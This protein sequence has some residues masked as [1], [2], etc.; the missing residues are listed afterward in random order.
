MLSGAVGLIAGTALLIAFILA[1]RLVTRWRRRRDLPLRSGY[2]LALAEYL[3][4]VTPDPPQ[5]VGPNERRALRHVALASLIELRGRERERVTELLERTGIVEE[6]TG[7]LRSRRRL[8]RRR[9]ADALAEIRSPE[10]APALRAGLDD[11]DRAVR[12]S[13]GRAL[14][15][16]GDAEALGELVAVA[17]TEIDHSPGAVADLLLALAA[18]NPRLLAEALPATASRPLRRLLIAIIGAERLVEYA[19]LLRSALAERDDELVARAAGG[20]GLMGDAESVEEL[21]GLLDDRDGALSVR[22]AAAEALGRIGDPAAVGALE[23]ALG[24]GDWTL[25]Q[26]A[27]EALSILGVPGEDMLRRVAASGSPQA[28]AH[29]EVALER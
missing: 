2:E 8:Q 29:A 7:E 5:P 18:Q 24:S 11:R 6:T 26:N 19:P 12:L 28:R 10:A 13:C 22:A 17:E 4:D 23:A 15:E 1:K 16:L 25:E 3:A 27:A 21:L 20:L 14:A 9:A